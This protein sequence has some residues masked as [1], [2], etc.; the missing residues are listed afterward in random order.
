MSD[1][2]DEDS[3]MCEKVDFMEVHDATS[4]QSIVHG[5][6]NSKDR[7]ERLWKAEMLPVAFMNLSVRL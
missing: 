5:L 3:V 1:S 7:F 4:S 6:L 2:V